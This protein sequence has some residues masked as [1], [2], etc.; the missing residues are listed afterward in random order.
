MA[1]AAASAGEHLCL[2][3]LRLE[4]IDACVFV[5]VCLYSVCMY[6]CIYERVCI[7]ISAE[8]KGLW[9]FDG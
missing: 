9:R 3:I 5:L 8:A 6:V 2:G 1:S 4:S 7:C